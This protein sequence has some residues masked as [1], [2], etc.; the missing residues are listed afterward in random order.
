MVTTPPTLARQAAREQRYRPARN[1]TDYHRASRR[2]AQ[3]TTTRLASS[4]PRIGWVPFSDV[5]VRAVY[6]PGKSHPMNVIGVPRL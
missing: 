4:S 6:C 5:S 2:G 1:P 3:L